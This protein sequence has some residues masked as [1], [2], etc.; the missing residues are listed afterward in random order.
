[1]WILNIFFQEVNKTISVHSFITE[2]PD[3]L[4]CKLLQAC[5]K[6]RS[7]LWAFERGNPDEFHTERESIVLIKKLGSGQFAEVWLGK[8]MWLK[9]LEKMVW[10]AQFKVVKGPSTLIKMSKQ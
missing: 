3:G 5:L 6:P 2:S 4:C 8:I 7:L 9:P 10:I 1:M